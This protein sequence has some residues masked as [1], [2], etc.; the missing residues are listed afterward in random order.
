MRQSATDTSTQ[1]KIQRISAGSEGRGPGVVSR[2]DLTKSVNV[3]L[4]SSKIASIAPAAAVTLTGIPRAVR[5]GKGDMVVEEYTEVAGVY[6]AAREDLRKAFEAMSPE[7]QAGGR[8]IVR[9]L[10]VRDEERML[11]QQGGVR[12]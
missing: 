11:E 9:G 6:A 2:D 1:N 7:E 3:M 10:R 5:R 8:A 12:R 4:Q